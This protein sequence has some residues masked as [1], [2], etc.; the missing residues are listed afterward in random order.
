MSL[1]E[2]KKR[3]DKMISSHRDDLLEIVLSFLGRL[4]TVIAVMVGLGALI[5]FRE[6]VLPAAPEFVIV[7]G[8]LLS[9]GW[10]GLL[11]WVAISGWYKLAETRG[12]SWSTHAIGAVVMVFSIFFIIAGAHAAFAN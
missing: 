8:V 9:I 2:T 3:I 6:V 11:V 10:F 4:V 1:T 12:Y 7:T 5:R